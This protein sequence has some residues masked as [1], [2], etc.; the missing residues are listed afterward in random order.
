[1]SRQFNLNEITKRAH[2]DLP[3]ELYLPIYKCVERMAKVCESPIEL[4]YAAGMEA[5]GLLYRME[6]PD[7]PSLVYVSDN[8]GPIPPCSV[9]LLP[10]CSFLDVGYRVDFIAEI[11]FLEYVVIECDG[12]D[13]HER[14]ADQAERD[15]T[16]DRTLQKMG[17]DVLR[18]TGREIN[19]SPIDC[20]RQTIE[21]LTEVADRAAK[22][23][24][25]A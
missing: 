23:R 22:I 24:K 1:V 3:P 12:H 10:Q 4:M 19:R 9:L 13:F 8:S 20:A 7:A 11:A 2:G 5:A 16:K 14:T 25:S 15:R 18:F 6:R 21:F 17:V